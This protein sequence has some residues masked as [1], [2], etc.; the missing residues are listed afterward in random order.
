MGDACRLAW[1]VDTG[2][3]DSLGFEFLSSAVRT[4]PG[5]LLFAFRMDCVWVGVVLGAGCW[6][7]GDAA[8]ALQAV[9]AWCLLLSCTSSLH[10]AA[11]HAMLGGEF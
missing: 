9:V 6:V 3:S 4:M 1:L 8:W 5:D 2:A 7:P 10:L 11:V